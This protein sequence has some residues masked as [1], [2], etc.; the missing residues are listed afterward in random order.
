MD[1]QEAKLIGGEV[2]SFLNPVKGMQRGLETHKPFIVAA[3]KH[4]EV[5]VCLKNLSV[6]TREGGTVMWEYK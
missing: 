1:V 5:P 4:K 6:F 3:F 2:L